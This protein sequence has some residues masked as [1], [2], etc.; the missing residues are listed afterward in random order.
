MSVTIFT[1]LGLIFGSF[2]NAFV[3][4]FHSGKNFVSGR[5]Q[6]VE[7]GHELAPKDLITVFSWLALRGRCRYCNEPISY[8]YPLVELITAGLFLGSFVWWPWM[9]ESGLSWVIFGLWLLALVG[10]VALAVYDLR[11]MELPDKIVFP[12]VWLAVVT[13]I[14]MAISDNSPDVFR[15]GL[16][17]FLLAF[18]FF[19]SLF[20]ISKGR[21]IGGGDVKYAAFMGVILGLSK[22][23]VALI[24]A[25]NIAAIVILPL[26]IGK[27]ITRKQPVPFGPFLI[28]STIIAL[29]FG[30][31]LIDWYS[32][33]FLYGVI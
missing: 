2:V 12:L 10:L 27:V 29:L 25:F 26:L 30:A 11:W 16:W 32:S 15:D 31:Q 5:S 7:C 21:W 9:L 4:R 20:Y 33:A 1:V 24:L 28:L 14:L 19:A 18:G 6:C 3:W 13:R 17:G 22:T 8:Q 23:V